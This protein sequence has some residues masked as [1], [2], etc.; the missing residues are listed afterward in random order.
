MKL[1]GNTILV[2]GGSSGIGLALATR[3]LAAGSRVIVCGRR[4][5]AL[6]AAAE[7]NPGLVT[8][9]CDLSRAEEREALVEWLV[10]AHPELNVLLNNA[11]IQ[12]RIKL[13][14][15]E[16]WETTRE[17]IAIN[18]DAPLHLTTLLL[19]HLRTRPD[20]AVIN[21]TSGLS[22]V[23]YVG[24]PVYSAT[25]AA[26]HSYTLSLRH[27]LADTPVRVI[28]IIP[29][30]VNTDLGGPGLHTTGEPLDA[31]ADAVVGRLAHG[32]IE[33]GYGS[34]EHRRLAANAVFD[35]WFTRMNG[36]PPR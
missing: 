3:F 9:Q 35:D 19:P 21:V 29:P 22:F 36:R 11:G 16:P 1:G 32:E 17:E 33:I 2:T 12:R 23:P 20:P 14:E 6:R 31:F 30:A 28:E 26:L 27:H 13:A 8:R 34:A 4:A 24:A 15:R 10:D 25:K 5:D 18:I 7:A